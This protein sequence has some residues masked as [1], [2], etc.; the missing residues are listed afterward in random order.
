MY[1]PRTPLRGSSNIAA[2]DADRSIKVF[3]EFRAMEFPVEA[4]GSL[5]NG[6]KALPAAHGRS[7]WCILPCRSS[8]VCPLHRRAIEGFRNRKRILYVSFR[9]TLG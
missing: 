8:I 4:S 3:K 6:Q 1:R 5:V 9:A 7:R 2:V